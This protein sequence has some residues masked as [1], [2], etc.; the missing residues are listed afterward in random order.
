MPAC[1]RR[2]LRSS[3]ATGALRA[4]SGYGD[5]SGVTL[6]DIYGSHAVYP[7]ET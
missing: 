2:L 6:A 3:A 1:G 5:N 4:S 7:S